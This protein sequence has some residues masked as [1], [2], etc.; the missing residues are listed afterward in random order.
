MKKKTMDFQEIKKEYMEEFG[1]KKG[2]REMM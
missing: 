2:M 1:G